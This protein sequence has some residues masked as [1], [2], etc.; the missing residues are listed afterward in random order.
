MEIQEV[1]A[2][3]S[4][5]ERK[6]NRLQLRGKH[7]EIDKCARKLESDVAFMNGTF[8]E[9]EAELNGLKALHNI[10]INSL[11]QKLLIQKPTVE[12]KILNYKHPYSAK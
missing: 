8:E 11:N 9:M 7:D 10:E 12:G 2:K 4:K 3:V 6:V 1:N 5:L